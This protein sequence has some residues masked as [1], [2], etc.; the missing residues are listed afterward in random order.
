MRQFLIRLFSFMKSFFSAAS[1]LVVASTALAQL[2]PDIRVVEERPGSVIIE[3]TPLSVS[4][5]RG[6][7]FYPGVYET[8]NGLEAPVRRL[9]FRIP[10]KY[11]SAEVLE[12]QLSRQ[13][14]FTLNIARS[15]GGTKKVGATV[16]HAEAR[17]V[18][19]DGDAFTAL[20]TLRPLEWNGGTVRLISRML[21]RISYDPLPSG[22]P[23]M[24]DMLKG[25][26]GIGKRDA[27]KQ[28]TVVNSPLAQG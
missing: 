12:Q 7:S 24:S 28:R 13:Q 20:L 14:S 2:P 6:L 21:V 10:S 17:A 15:S 3:F 5:E 18:K 27:A 8:I 1:I 26:L 9:S 4:S 23:S 22:S 11:I 19:S 16:L 25:E